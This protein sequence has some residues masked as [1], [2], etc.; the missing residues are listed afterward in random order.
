MLKGWSIF[1]RDLLNLLP[2]FGEEV[3]LYRGTEFICMIIHVFEIRHR[4]HFFRL[5]G[6]FEIRRLQQDD[7]GIHRGAFELLLLCVFDRLIFIGSCLLFR[8]FV[9]RNSWN[10][11]SC[12]HRDGR[13][14]LSLIDS[15]KWYHLRART[16][17]V[18][19]VLHNN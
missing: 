14:N 9:E 4:W 8:L 12:A 1:H 6:L 13:M 7:D 16:F 18:V 3:F 2:S 17:W 15:P 19:A 11:Q 10:Q 5:F